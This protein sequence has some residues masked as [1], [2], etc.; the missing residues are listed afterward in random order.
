V[1]LL[2]WPKSECVVHYHTLLPATHPL[3]DNPLPK[4]QAPSKE[5]PGQTPESP[6]EF[7]QR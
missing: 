4:M 7:L 3:Y 5:G 1:H 2:V 6:A